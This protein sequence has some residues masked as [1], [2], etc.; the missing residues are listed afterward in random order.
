[1]IPISQPHRR[2]RLLPWSIELKPWPFYSQLADW[3]ANLPDPNA[4]NNC[5]PECVAMVMKFLTGVELPANVI[6]DAIYGEGYVGYSNVPDLEAYLRNYCETDAATILTRSARNQAWW[7]WRYL[8]QGK[9]LIGLFWSTMVN[10]R[11]Q[12]GHFRAV[13]GQTPHTVITADPWTGTRRVE[14]IEEHWQ[15]SKGL[16]IGVDRVRRLG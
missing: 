10:G 6:K 7:E 11:G 14:T 12:G 15:W 4:A 5:G 8:K 16:L 2:R 1:M 9:P 3:R 13:I